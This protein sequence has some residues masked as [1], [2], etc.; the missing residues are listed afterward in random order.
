WKGSKINKTVWALGYAGWYSIVPVP[1]YYKYSDIFLKEVYVCNII[2]KFEIY[3][4]FDQG[5]V[6]LLFDR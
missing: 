2:M 4:I 1:E 5:I 3:K 6:Q